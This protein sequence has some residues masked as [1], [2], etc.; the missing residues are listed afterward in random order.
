[1]YRYKTKEELDTSMET[2]K[3]LVAAIQREDETGVQSI[4]SSQFPYINEL[5]DCGVD[6]RSNSSA[7]A[8]SPLMIAAELGYLGIVERLLDHPEIDVNV[9]DADSWTALVYAIKENR[10][11]VAT[12]LINNDASMNKVGKL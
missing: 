6:E 11:D 4:L 5:V 7:G 2:L 12:L 3:R 9:E 8:H 1:M 10:E